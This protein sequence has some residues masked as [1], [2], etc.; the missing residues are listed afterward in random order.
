MRVKEAQWIIL[1]CLILLVNKEEC[2]QASCKLKA[3]LLSLVFHIIIIIFFHCQ[4]NFQ[5]NRQ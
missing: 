1:G 3:E 5:N 4:V 2:S